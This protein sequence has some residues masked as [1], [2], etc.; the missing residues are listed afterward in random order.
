MK[1]ASD[2]VTDIQI[3]YIGGGSR[4]WAWILM[5]DLAQ[6]EQLSG[7]VRLYDID[8]EAAR[9]NETIGNALAQRS[10]VNG[11][12]QYEA[13]DTL[14]RAVKD[15]DFVVISI[16]PG[17]FTEMESDVHAPEQ[18]G[19]HQPVGDT[20]GAGGIIRALRTLPMYIEFAEAIRDYAPR[21]WVINYTN[22]MTLCT[23]MLYEVFPEI[24]AFGCCHE[25]FST[26]KLL[27]HIL[28]HHEGIQEDIPRE[29]IKTN[30]LGINHFTWLDRASWKN[31]NLLPIYRKFV[32]AHYETG[33]EGLEPW[34]ARVFST[35]HRVKFDLFR[36]YGLI[37][38]AGDRHLAEFV[39]PAWYLKDPQTV[40]QWKFHLTPVS[41][42]INRQQE[43]KE[44][45]ETLLRD[46]QQLELK[47]SG[48]E[49]VQQI[50]ALV[51]LD[52]LVTN[53][54]LPNCGQLKNIPNGAVVETNAVFRRD[55]VIPVMA[56][57][58]PAD[59]HNLVSRHVY[60]QETLVQAAVKKDLDLA[61]NAFVNDPMLS[62][63]ALRDAKQ[64]FVTMVDNTKAYL[65]GWGT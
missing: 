12:W 55:S 17:T 11:R 34:T 2:S 46:I 5:G 58:L 44:K 14:E 47:D 48:E 19:I 29:A 7:T 4:G 60:N 40:K 16:Q 21:A 62:G 37:A 64:L 45:A 32:D 3:A 36:R 39:P 25:V 22:P 42:R 6:E 26:Q 28:M 10:D 31:L 20:V 24:K 38:A 41:W 8:H 61:F 63:L 33:Y 50:K 43:L 65:P 27:A 59:I 35:A 54:N 15:A 23:R 1:Y 9:A 13:V 57:A 51:G 53:V 49:G 56:G 18:Y 30:V 52:D